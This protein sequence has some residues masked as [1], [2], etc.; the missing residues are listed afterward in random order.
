M[1]EQRKINSAFQQ[2][3]LPSKL[4]IYP[5]LALYEKLQLKGNINYNSLPVI[6][7]HGY[8]Y[9]SVPK[10]QSLSIGTLQ[11]NE[12]PKIQSTSPKKKKS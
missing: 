10:Q 9:Q 8:N 2:L 12:L 11:R 6:N 7:L 5:N 4:A 3:N 1:R